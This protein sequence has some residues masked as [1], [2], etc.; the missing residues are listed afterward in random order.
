MNPLP[1]SRLPPFRWRRIA[2]DI[3]QECSYNVL[4]W[5]GKPPRVDVCHRGYEKGCGRSPMRAHGQPKCGRP[6]RR[7]CPG[8]RSFGGQFP[9]GM[10]SIVHFRREGFTRSRGERGGLWPLCSASSRLHVSR[11]PISRWTWGPSFIFSLSVNLV[12]DGPAMRNFVFT[13]EGTGRPG[14]V[15]CHPAAVSAG[16]GVHPSFLLSVKFSSRIARPC[17]SE[18][19]DETGPMGASPAAAP[20]G[21]GSIDR[22]RAARSGLG[23][24]DAAGLPRL[25]R[26]G[27]DHLHA[28][29]RGP[30][31][32][33]G[34]SGA[35]V[36]GLS[37]TAVRR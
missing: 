27:G 28:P 13:S 4:F 1:R 26:A 19:P 14:S 20:L 15:G 25:R 9:L 11:T 30:A 3:G 37:P 36:T 16:H 18:G 12:S 24:L 32:A 7:R 8:L 35:G 2:I 22:G 21:M 10:G 5:S 17:T 31:G 6:S 23:A 34:A 33:P 29:R